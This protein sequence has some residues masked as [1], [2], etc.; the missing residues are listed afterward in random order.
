[1]LSQHGVCGSH[2]CEAAAGENCSHVGWKHGPW[3]VLF[4]GQT[5]SVDIATQTRASTS[6]ISLAEI[7]SSIPGCQRSTR[8]FQTCGPYSRPAV[9]DNGILADYLLHVLFSCPSLWPAF[10]FKDVVVSSLLFLVSSPL[11]RKW[12]TWQQSGV[13]QATYVAHRIGAL[14]PRHAM[15]TGCFRIAL[16]P[17]HEILHDTEACCVRV[18]A[19]TAASQPARGAEISGW[20]VSRRLCSAT[21][22]PGE[23]HLVSEWH[24][25][26][27]RH[28]WPLWGASPVCRVLKTVTHCSGHFSHFSPCCDLLSRP[29]WCYHSLGL[30]GLLVHTVSN[31]LCRAL[32]QQTKLVQ[33][34]RPKRMWIWQQPQDQVRPQVVAIMSLHP[35]RYFPQGKR[36]RAVDGHDMHQWQ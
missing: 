23:L 26:A 36:P 28:H 10:C 31:Q 18:V 32:Q 25:E 13:S 17:S 14:H 24:S 19:G 35:G 15:Q 7:I 6:H 2:V 29:G 30:H 27:A 8:F 16:G 22:A 33:Q 21:T 11:Q 20:I 9:C 12:A 3:A 1:M 34:H 5:V 4:L